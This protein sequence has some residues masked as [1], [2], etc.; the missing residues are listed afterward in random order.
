MK[1][2]LTHRNYAGMAVRPESVNV[3]LCDAGISVIPV[4]VFEN[5]SMDECLSEDVLDT[6]LLLFEPSQEIALSIESTERIS[7]TQIKL[8]LSLPLI[9]FSEELKFS[10][11]VTPERSITDISYDAEETAL[12]ITLD[13]DVLPTEDILIVSTENRSVRYLGYSGQGLPWPELSVTL[14]GKPEGGVT[15][16]ALGVFTSTPALAVLGITN[17]TAFIAET[18]IIVQTDGLILQQEPVGSLPI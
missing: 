14:N 11:T 4:E 12:Y 8:E 9:V 6:Y 7:G 16:E 10:I 2:V 15:Q 18:G 13:A 17:K 3:Q 5:E 1:W